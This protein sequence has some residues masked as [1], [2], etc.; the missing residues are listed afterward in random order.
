MRKKYQEAE[1]VVVKRH[2]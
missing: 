1:V 2:R